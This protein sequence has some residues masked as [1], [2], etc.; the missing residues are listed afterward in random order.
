MNAEILRQ[1]PTIQDFFKIDPE[2][3]LA[4]GTRLLLEAMEEVEIPAGQDIVTFG[5][6]ATDGMYI[7]LEGATDVLSAKGEL[8]NTLGEGDFIGELGLINDDTR[9]ATVRA[10]TPVRCANISKALFEEIA[11]KNRKIY[12][13]FMN[14]LYTKTTKL[15]SEQE[16]IKADLSVA[17]RIQE[18]CLEDDFTDFNRP[19]SFCITAR[20]RPAKEVG[21]DFYDIFWIDEK[22]LCF[23]IA[24]VSGK[25]IPAALFM[26]MA[27]THLKNYA[28]LGLS[29][30]EVVYR[31]NNQLCYRNDE[32]MFVTAFVCVLDVEKDEVI[33]VNA[34]H[35]RPFLSKG[36]GAFEMISCKANLVLGMMPDFPY[37]EQVLELKPGDALYLYTDGVT[38]ALNPQK[39]LLGDDR[40]L[41]MLNNHITQ[42]GDQEAFLEAMYE[43]VDGF[44]D[45]EMQADDITM[46]YLTRKV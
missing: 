18:S 32:G 15:V 14:M 4:E 45:G 34:G 8:I 30:A 33:F 43:E 23:L 44:A 28:T 31:A 24:D 41:A 37:K 46:V 12:G 2:K 22:H 40:C 6:E 36:D 1:I 29:L 26:T 3:E 35:N 17:K 21:G 27:K 42:A 11:M 19:S 20:M 25:G 38:E 16:R 9:G 13:T 39:E 10:N 7:I 5:A